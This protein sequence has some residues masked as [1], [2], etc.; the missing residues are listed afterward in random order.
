[1]WKRLSHMQ[2]NTHNR[3][4]RICRGVGRLSFFLFQTGC[5]SPI[6]VST[7]KSLSLDIARSACQIPVLLKDTSC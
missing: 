1:M 3:Y 2:E 5:L 4:D 7:Y 6:L